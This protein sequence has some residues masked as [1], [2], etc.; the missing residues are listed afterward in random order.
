MLFS[1]THDQQPPQPSCE[2]FA[3]T[4]EQEAAV[5]NA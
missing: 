2:A 1:E 3:T 5:T 4:D